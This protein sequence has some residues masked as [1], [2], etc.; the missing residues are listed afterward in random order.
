[1]GIFKDDV[2]WVVALPHLIFVFGYVCVFFVLLIS[3]FPI[4]YSLVY[5]IV[6]LVMRWVFRKIYKIRGNDK[7][8]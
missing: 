3:G 5:I 2:D 6:G 4:T 8:R 1:M 7:R